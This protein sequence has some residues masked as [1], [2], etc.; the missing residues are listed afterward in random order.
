MVFP[1]FPENR[2]FYI[3]RVTTDLNEEADVDGQT[4]GSNTGDQE[5][6]P[7]NIT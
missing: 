5:M 3:A 1:D 2:D 4:L 7:G 6:R